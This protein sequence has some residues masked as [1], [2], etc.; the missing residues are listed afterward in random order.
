MNNITELDVNTLPESFFISIIA[1]RRSG[2]SVL[3]QSL[4]GEIQQTK[5][6]LILFYYLV[7]QMQ[8]LK[9]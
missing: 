4:L 8:D 3:I 7:Q 6:D 9:T 1:S 5:K 2:K